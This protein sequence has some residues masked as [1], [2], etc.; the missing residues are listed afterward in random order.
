MP[1]RRASPHL[2]Q[3]GGHSQP[4][5]DLRR[6]RGVRVRRVCKQ[7]FAVAWRAVRLRRQAFGAPV[8]HKVAWDAVLARD[9]DRAHLQCAREAIVFILDTQ[10]GERGDESTASLSGYLRGLCSMLQG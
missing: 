10:L 5:R 3:R 1:A 8:A 7:R 2:Q 4:G 9:A 6:R